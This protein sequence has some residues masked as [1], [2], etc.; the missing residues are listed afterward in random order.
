MLKNGEAKGIAVPEEEDEAVRDLLRLRED[1]MEDE[2][3]TKQELLKLLLRYGYNYEE[4][5]HYWTAAHWKWMEGLKFSQTIDK[6]VYE[7]YKS[8]IKSLGE[9][10][11]RL[12]VRIEEI[13]GSKRYKAKVQ[14]FRA[15]KGVDTLTALSL[16]V[17]IGDFQRFGKAPAFMSYLGLVPSENSSGGKR[18]QGGITKAGNTHLRK[19]LIES[20]WHYP[21]GNQAGKKLMERRK[22]C[23]ASVIDQAD[24]AMHRLNKKYTRLVL[25]KGKM[26]TVAITAVARELAG[27]LWAV[28]YQMDG[29]TLPLRDNKSNEKQKRVSKLAEKALAA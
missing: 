8:M 9:R 23:Q 5:K 24:K 3:R 12:N 2:K 21:R 1:I 11:E 19:L 7:E 25:A 15:F 17:E 20:A 14:N 26:K 18:R 28:G 22:G 6:E 13:A 29:G 10:E 4:G 16:D 27:F